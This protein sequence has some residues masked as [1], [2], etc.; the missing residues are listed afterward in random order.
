MSPAIGIKTDSC[1]PRHFQHILLLNSESTSHHSCF[2]ATDL[3]ARAFS[4]A[5][6]NLD[7]RRIPQGDYFVT[8]NRFETS[9]PTCHKHRLILHGRILV[10]ALVDTVVGIEG[11]V[12]E[13]VVVT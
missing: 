4:R 6:R 3:Y 12:A 1:D 10:E 5:S 8:G 2:P 11:M 7:S 13:G 9:S